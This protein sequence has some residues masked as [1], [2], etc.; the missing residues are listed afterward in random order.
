MNT[1]KSCRKSKATRSHEPYCAK[2]AHRRRRAARKAGCR[3]C[4]STNMS[5]PF[6]RY[7]T[8]CAREVFP[9]RAPH[10]Q[11]HKCGNSAA[12]AQGICRPCWEAVARLISAARRQSPDTA[13]GKGTQSKA[14][15]RRASTSAAA[16]GAPTTSRQ[17]TSSKPTC[18]PNPARV[19]AQTVA[20]R[21][22]LRVV[23][24]RSLMQL[25]TPACDRPQPGDDWRHK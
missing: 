19:S 13:T 15:I 8:T 18:S 24:E 20:A 11:C 16:I 22:R 12:L 25:A 4:G 7:C 1:C 21:P 5:K 23:R 3:I 9:P 10:R 2:C 6:H 14:H 17:L